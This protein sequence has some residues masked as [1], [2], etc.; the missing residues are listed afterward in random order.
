[1]RIPSGDLAP[2]RRHRRGYGRRRNPLPIVVAVVL[3]VAVATGAYLLRRDDSST[4]AVASASR[5]PSPSAA[6]PVKAAPARVAAPVRLP[7]PGQVGLRLLNGTGRDGLA[8]TVGNELARRGFKV[9][10]MGNAPKAL[11]GASRVYFGPGGRPAALLVSTHVLGGS[12]VPVPSAGHGAVD[13][14]LGSTFM[15]LRTPAEA[16]AYA[17]NLASTGIATPKSAAL[18]PTIPKSA[19]S[20]SCR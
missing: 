3:V 6:A 12:V 4:G 10:A 8:R 15:R 14:V 20:P 19:T 9:T 17:S 18:K 7:A 5:C 11:V 2:A 1:M 13:V 16:S